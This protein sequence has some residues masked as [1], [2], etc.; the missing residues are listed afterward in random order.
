MSE[1]A[2]LRL[3]G[4]S[5]G[6]LSEVADDVFDHDIDP[7]RLA[8]YLAE[9]GHLM[10]IAVADGRVIGQC[11]AAI[12][13]HVD[14]PT[15]LYIDNLGVAEAFKR[16]GV[17]SRLVQAMFAWGLELGC[18][19]AWVATEPDNAEGRGFYEAGGAAPTPIMMYEYELSSEARS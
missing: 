16:R 8:A 5:A 1:I 10:T 14:K 4:D 9:P 19:E 6:L 2:I 18:E 3:G 7:A 15:E 12:H 13:R 11:Q 17:A